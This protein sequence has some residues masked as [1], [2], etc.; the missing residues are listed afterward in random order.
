V[1]VV[2]V[3]LE[4]G[5][6]CGADA[7]TTSDKPAFRRFHG[8]LYAQQRTWARTVAGRGDTSV[9]RYQITSGTSSMNSALRL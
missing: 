4:G 8:A 3:R 5:S 7:D 6:P 9:L 1:V 2:S